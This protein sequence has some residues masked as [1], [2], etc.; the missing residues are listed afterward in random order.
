VKQFTRS[1]HPVIAFITTLVVGV[2]GSVGAVL[3]SGR[4]PFD[5]H[6]SWGQAMAAATFAFFLLFWWYGVVP[7]QWLMLA[8]NEWGWR[9]DR[10]YAGPGGIVET[11]LPF[12]VT[13]LV[14]RDF[15]VLGIYG[16]ALGL[17]IWHW[18]QW[19]DRKKKAAAR[20]AELP[21][22]QYGR[23]LVKKA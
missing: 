12:E 21:A 17:N 2:L 4:R 20:A 5:A 15:I 19:N 23:P 10:M 9:S 22:S 7:H 18:A 13:Y 8:D 6:L 3:Y 14:L 1:R 11:A 16:L